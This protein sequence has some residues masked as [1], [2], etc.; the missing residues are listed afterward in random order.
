M[1]KHELEFIRKIFKDYFVEYEDD[2]VYIESH[3]RAIKIYKIDCADVQ[4]YAYTIEYESGV[5]TKYLTL[6][7]CTQMGLNYIVKGDK[8]E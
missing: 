7:E 8:N 5:M 2:V 6:D 4:E 3:N 1:D